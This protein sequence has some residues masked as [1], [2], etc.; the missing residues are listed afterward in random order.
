MRESPALQYNAF[1]RAMIC[2]EPAL[3]CTWSAEAYLSPAGM[4]L[5]VDVP[6][7]DLNP[8]YTAPAVQIV[9]LQEA[10][11]ASSAGPAAATVS[12]APALWMMQEVSNLHGLLVHPCAT[13]VWCGGEAT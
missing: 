4:S 3:P 10:P 11:A 2:A 13:I 5:P 6:V 8:E 9:P 1:S 12:L 7:A